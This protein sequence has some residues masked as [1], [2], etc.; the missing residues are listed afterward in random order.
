[1]HS[2]HLLGFQLQGPVL[3]CPASPVTCVPIQSFALSSG[4]QIVSP[5]GTDT[6]HLQN[7]GILS[8]KGSMRTT[9]PAIPITTS[10]RDQELAK[11]P[12]ERS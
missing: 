9:S 11:Y 4:E 1:M 5:M 2:H 10:G 12:K 8:G 7:H 3:R 6:R